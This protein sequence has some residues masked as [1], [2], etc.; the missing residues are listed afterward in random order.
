MPDEPPA[1]DPARDPDRPSPEEQAAARRL[2][3]AGWKLC[4]IAGGSALI[5]LL[6]APFALFALLAAVS[7]RRRARALEVEHAARHATWALLLALASCAWQASL[8][9]MWWGRGPV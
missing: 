3:S 7:T 9:A 4:V 2:G 6:G 5:P 8:I 1:D